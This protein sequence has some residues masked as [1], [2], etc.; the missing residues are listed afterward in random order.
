MNIVKAA[1]RFQRWSGR[2][3]M[4]ALVSACAVASAGRAVAQETVNYASVSGRVTD[5]SGAVVTGA[6]VIARQTETNLTAAT[7]TDGEGRFRFPYLKVGP[8]EITLRKTG[9]ADVI[10]SLTLTLGAAFDLSVSLTVGTV[11][12]NVSV[13]AQAT[14]I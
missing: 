5:P 6:Q 2:A 9:F 8:Y 13:T 14:V 7:E 12:A 3:V 11:E 1:N 10:R 4:A